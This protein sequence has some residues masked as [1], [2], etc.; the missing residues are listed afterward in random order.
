MN[1][2]SQIVLASDRIQKQLMKKMAQEVSNREIK[3]K[4]DIL[5]TARAQIN[6]GLQPEALMQESQ[7][8]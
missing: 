7:T 8:E 4:E 5:K 6:F 2:E 3:K 1:G